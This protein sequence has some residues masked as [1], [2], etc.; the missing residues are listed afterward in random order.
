MCQFMPVLLIKVRPG[1]L[2]LCLLVAEVSKCKKPRG[3]SELQGVL[4]GKWQEDSR[5]VVESSLL[6]GIS[7]SEYLSV[8][9]FSD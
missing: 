3:R 2:W 7:L 5:S 6:E 9:T 4:H 8:Q 1:S